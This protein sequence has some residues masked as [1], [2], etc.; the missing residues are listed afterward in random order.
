MQIKKQHE[1]KNKVI[2]KALD[3]I[4]WWYDENKK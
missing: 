4:K 2:K 3:M 1:H